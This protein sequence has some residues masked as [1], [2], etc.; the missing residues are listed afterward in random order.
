MPAAATPVYERK[1][2]PVEKEIR[3]IEPL[4]E[5]SVPRTSEAPPVEPSKTVEKPE[6]AASAESSIAKAAQSVIDSVTAQAAAG[7]TP[8]AT[9]DAQAPPQEGDRN[10]S[11]F[12]DLFPAKESARQPVPE[13]APPAAPVPPPAGGSGSRRRMFITVGVVIIILIALAGGAF[14]YWNF[15]KGNGSGE[16]TGTEPTPDGTTIP[17]TTVK[18]TPVPTTAKTVA[19]TQGTPAPTQALIPEQGVWVHV[20]YPNTFKG[21]VGTAGNQQAVSDTGD[22]FYSISTAEGIVEASIQK[23]DGSGEEL[24]VEV[25]KNGS[26]VKR[27]TTTVPRGTVEIRAD[28]KPPTTLTTQPTTIDT[29]IPSANTTTVAANVTATGTT[30]SP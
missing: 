19:T 10:R 23:A 18:T 6:E 16:G 22:K 13:G 30:A 25:Y 5:G 15:L 2:R 8:A 7:G 24:V 29:T 26:L 12:P 14:L 11:V 21:S 4:I 3:S 20:V 9:G 28:L 1:E 27:G 17:V